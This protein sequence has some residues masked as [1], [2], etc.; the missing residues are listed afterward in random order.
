MFEQIQNLLYMY[1][2][3]Y[4]CCPKYVFPLG[5]SCCL[6]FLMSFYVSVNISF[7]HVINQ[8]KYTNICILVDLYIIHI[9][10]FT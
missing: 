10:L 2:Q 3:N 8:N 6:F 4:I 9:N 1:I 7:K 5:K